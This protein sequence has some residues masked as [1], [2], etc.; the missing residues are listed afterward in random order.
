MHLEQQFCKDIFKMKYMIN[1]EQS[2][3]EVVQ[4]I[5]K[6]IA[7][8]E[9]FYK[10][11]YWET[12]FYEAIM[13]RKFIPAGRILA[14]ARPNSKLKNYGNCY[15]IGFDDS[16]KGIYLKGLAEDAFISAAGGGVGFNVSTLRP[17]NAPITR[18]GESSG[19][20]SF[21]DV[22]D[23]SAKTIRNGGGRRCLPLWYR[24][25]MGDGSLKEIKDII[26]G[27][28][29]KFDGKVYKVKNKYLNGVQPLLKI[30]T[31]R[32]WHV[33]TPGHRW[34]VRDLKTGNFVWKKAKDLADKNSAPR[35]AFVVP[36]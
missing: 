29:I 33:S 25:E 21:L 3:E 1:G 32:G 30:N 7:S 34:L 5:A 20:M 36:K 14:N 12:T 19:P 11:S 6:E 15:V 10:K 31:K 22:F 4:G 9:K 26:I 35:Y 2:Q 13:S 17:K 24:V 28:K 23:A 18:G 8:V 27:D 16:L